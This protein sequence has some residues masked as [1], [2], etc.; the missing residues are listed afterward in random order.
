MTSRTLLIISAILLLPVTLRAEVEKRAWGDVEGAPVTLYT[1]RNAKNVTLRVTNYGAALVGIVM[2]DRGGKMNDVT[3]GFGDLQGYLDHRYIGTTVG[4][5]G[6]RIAKGAFTLDGKEYKLATNGGPNHL[7]GGKRGFDTF[8]WQGEA[9]DGKD[10]ACVRFMRVS[11]DGEEG[12]PGTL[13]VSVTYTLTDDTAVR[14]DYIATTDKPTPINL[15]NHSHFNLAG[16]DGASVEP[17]VDHVL[18][19]HAERY[20]PVDGTRIPTGELAPLEGT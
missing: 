15:T 3:L 9:T 4:R 12:Y 2:P 5:Y 16:T 20:T 11:P 1:V 19:I 8:V 14:I 13:E 18:T 17:I 6:N 10:G 7:H